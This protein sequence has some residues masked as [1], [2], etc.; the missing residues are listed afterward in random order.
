[1]IFNFYSNPDFRIYFRLDGVVEF[2]L[3]ELRFKIAK[4]KEN[5]LIFLVVD[6]TVANQ[7][8]VII[9]Q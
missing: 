2:I 8:G 5:Y 6:E 9:I 3:V 4:N 1:M 7:S